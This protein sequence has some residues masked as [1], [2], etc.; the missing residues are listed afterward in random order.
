MM[1]ADE[2]EEADEACCVSCGI[3]QV[4]EIKLKI[5]TA[6]KSVRYCSVECQ[7]K[8][9]SQHKRACKKRAAELRDKILF[10]QPESSHLG[11][12]PICCLP[13][14]ID[15]S[16]STLMPC[17]T[18]MICMGCENANFVREVEE[19]LG[20]RCPFC[21]ES[22]TF[23]REEVE[24]NLM[25]RI[26]AND[27]VA[28]SEVGKDRYCEAD[29][30]GA[31]DYWTKAAGLGNIDA[32]Y[33]LSM[34]YRNGQ[35]VERDIKKAIYHWEQ[36]AI[37]GHPIARHHLGAIEWGNGRREWALKHWIISAK[38]GHDDAL[39]MLKKVYKAGLVSK[40]DFAAA[41]RAHQT[42]VDATKSPQ[43]EAA[44]RQ[45]RG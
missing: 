28:I 25:N 16:K 12:C 27:P 3:T 20:H 13:L 8:H 10:R 17:C 18:K 41:L 29:Y 24:M 33:E 40:E 9:R 36:A 21:R 31:F 4:D 42:A 2:E 38:L 30:N 35:G 7:K 45:N 22:R 23:T 11:D 14:F 19:S 37:G 5:C 39:E 32:H 15:P 43:R 26:E 44:D 1:S 34:M 6:C